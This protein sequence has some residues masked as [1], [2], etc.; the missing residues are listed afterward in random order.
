MFRLRTDHSSLQ[1]L[2]NFRE[3]KG[4]LAR[5]LEQLQEYDF[6]IVHRAGGKH[7]NADAMSRRPSGC[8]QM[9]S[10]TTADCNN[11]DNHPVAVAQNV[12][13]DTVE[14][15]DEMYTFQINDA[16]ISPIL[17]AKKTGTKPTDDEL[18]GEG[19]AVHILLQ[20]WD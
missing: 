13:E 16:V 19:R 20:Q 5:W 1:W 18:K 7:S 9:V 11:Q 17:H 14:T 3:L 2:Q 10:Q 4:Q 15:T 12:N 8:D 6:T